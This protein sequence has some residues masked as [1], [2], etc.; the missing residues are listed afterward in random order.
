[1]MHGIAS[2]L[3]NAARAVARRPGFSALVMLTLAVGIGAATAMF[4]V[5]DGVLQSPLPY[6][7]TARLIQVR[8]HHKGRV[9]GTNSA[10]NF[11]DYREQITSVQSVAAHQYG[12][13][14]LGETTEPR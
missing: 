12:R 14:L 2:D 9:H 13:W 4:S 1:M 5:V 11:L 6:P 8:T 10:A 7:E 3:T